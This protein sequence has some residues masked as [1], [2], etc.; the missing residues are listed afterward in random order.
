MTDS[1]DMFNSADNSDVVATDLSYTD[2]IAE[3]V[4]FDDAQ[5]TRI[6]FVRC[7][8]YWASFFRAELVNVSFEHCD[9][10]GSDFKAS[11]LIN[12]RFIDCDLGKD[13]IGGD[14]QFGGASLSSVEFL[15][16]LGR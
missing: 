13:A 14:T 5:L 2:C 8:M 7:D 3:G 12:C 1:I 6:N 10:W 4:H 15:N 9:L 11:R 16:C